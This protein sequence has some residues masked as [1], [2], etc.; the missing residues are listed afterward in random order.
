MTLTAHCVTSDAGVSAFLKAALKGF[1]L[2]F[3]PSAGAF[4]RAAPGGGLAVIDAFLPDMSGRDLAAVLR[5]DQKTR[6]LS[7]VLTGAGPYSPA[8]AAVCFDNGADEYFAFPPEPRLF[9]ARL[10]NLLA[11]SCAAGPAPAEKPA[12]YR[13]KA[14]LVSPE[15]RTAQIGRAAL[16]LTALEFDLLVYFLRNQG[17]VVSRSVL[18]EQVWRQGMEAGLRSVDKRIEALR[19]KLGRP[20]GSKI[21]TVFGLGYIFK[22]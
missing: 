8:A 13:F 3:Y 19:Y 22:L 18:L 20:F 16:K 21:K 17:R 9:R 5:G 15:A 6:R 2:K 14:L 1:R 10:V 11:R 12:E 4:L 7:L